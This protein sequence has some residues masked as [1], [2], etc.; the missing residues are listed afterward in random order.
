MTTNALNILPIK[1][2]SCP[3]M[4][5]TAKKKKMTVKKGEHKVGDLV[6]YD[7]NHNGTPDHIG[8]V[9]GKGKNYIRAIEGNTG[10]GSNTNGGQV[11]RRKRAMSDILGFVRPKYTKEITPYMIV[12]TA[13]NELGV[14][15]SPKNSNKV[16]Y[17]K[18]FYGRNASA[19]WC[20][21]FVCW[22]YGNV[23]DIPKVSKPTGKYFGTVSKET[24]KYGSEGKKV[25]QLQEFLNWYHKDW[26]LKPDGKCGKKTT[27]AVMS[28]Q[29]TE[30]LKPDGIFGPKSV[31]KAKEYTKNI[32]EEKLPELPKTAGEL[33]VEWARAR[34]AE[35]TFVYKLWNSKDKKTK[36]CPICYP[37][38]KGKYHGGNCIWL[39]T[40][41]YYHGA[42]LRSIKCGCNGL[43]TNSFFT[44]V[45][46]A[47]WK[48][49]NGDGWKMITNGG[50]KGGKSIPVSKLM[51]GDVL[52]C[53]DEKG[54]FH[55]LV[56][57][58]GDGKYVECTRGRKPQV[59]ERP[60][61]KLSKKHITRAFR[62]VGK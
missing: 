46:E 2:D 19:F 57:Y 38:L 35:G 62:Y 33:A 9:V 20:C 32:P 4:W 10:S 60:M 47:S 49:R 5:N 1:T 56:M 52:I 36:L 17:N 37:S 29:K 39:P 14:K 40:A 34:I 45:T 58:S 41:A 44:K 13:L 59:G 15:E 50:S 25:K 30:G 54:K 22:N 3:V 27:K 53:Y 24:V 12:L 55:H 28:F 18:W 26:A 21:T 48:K 11:Q 6:L 7:F 43:G 23:I 8:I 51:V 61:S 31:A 16:K 42:G